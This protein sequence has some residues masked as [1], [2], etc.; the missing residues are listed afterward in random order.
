[1]SDEIYVVQVIPSGS[2]GYPYD[3]VVGIS[4]CKV[5]MVGLTFSLLFDGIVNYD[6][7]HLGG[8]KMEN[9]SHFGITEDDVRNGMDVR[10]IADSVMNLLKGKDVTSFDV[11]QE[12]NRYLLSSPWGL[13]GNV[14]VVRPISKKLPI[15][16]R[17]KD[18][19]DSPMIVKKA[20]SRLLKGNPYGIREGTMASKLA[21]M[22]SAVMVDMRKR[23]KY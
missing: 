3:E 12:F 18:P 17:C 6:V 20:Y 4:I 10:V 15:S 21:L 7:R 5:D 14:N 2:D 11:D 16:L 9:L 19:S 1:M 13:L 23:G 8:K 22:A